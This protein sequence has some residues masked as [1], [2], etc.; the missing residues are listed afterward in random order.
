MRILFDFIA[1]ILFFATYMLTKNMVWATLVAVVAGIFQAAFTYWKFKKLEPMQW[2]SLILIVVFGGL[3]IV[4]KDRT[5]FMLKTTLLTWLMAIVMLVAQLRGKNG[6]RVVLSKEVQLPDDVWHKL[7]YAW[8]V[9]FVG[10]GLLNLIIAYPFDEA[11]EAFWVQFK[12]WGY[13]PLTIIFS[14]AQAVYMMRHLPKEN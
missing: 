10:L 6:L 2:V 14:I 9:F 4:L 11:S 13:L 7:S 5:F 12:L 1:I 8:I 3:T